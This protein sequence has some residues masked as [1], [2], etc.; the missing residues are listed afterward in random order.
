[1]MQR[2]KVE[3]S[4]RYKAGIAG[5]AMILA[6]AIGLGLWQWHNTRHDSQTLSS[7]NDIAQKLNSYTDTHKTVPADLKTVGVK[8]VSKDITYK[9]VSDSRYEFCVSFRTQTGFFG[10]FG[11]DYYYA[12]NQS[13][14][15]LYIDSYHNKGKRCEKVDP[16]PNANDSSTTP[17]T[18][19]SVN[20]ITDPQ[21]AANASAKQDSVCQISGFATHYAAKVTAVKTA[22]GQPVVPTVKQALIVTVKPLTDTTIADKSEQNLTISQDSGEIYNI[23]NSNCTSLSADNLQVGDYVTVFQ[24]NSSQYMPNAIADFS[25]P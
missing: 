9:R 25:R 18:A 17:K 16:L 10:P 6:G 2:I 4:W 7:A 19:P 12:D 22:D 15:A 23:F 1:M 8:S 24:A 11:G 14:S 5:I 3:T 20:R 13:Q 21:Q